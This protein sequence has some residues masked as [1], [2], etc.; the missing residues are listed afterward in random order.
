MKKAKSLLFISIAL[1]AMGCKNE[2]KENTTSEET[3][4][5]IDTV[6]IVKQKP[7]NE[8]NSTAAFDLKPSEIYSKDSLPKAKEAYAVI[9]E[10]TLNNNKCSVIAF[11]SGEASVTANGNDIQFRNNRESFKPIATSLVE[12]GQKSLALFT[13]LKTRVEPDQSHLK[14]YVLTGDGRYVFESKISEI[15]NKEMH[16]I[17]ENALKLFAESRKAM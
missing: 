7:I 17:Y 2:S 13:P 8:I 1:L 14:I 3:S 11:K 10:W 9:M 12:K 6:V 15:K 16:A 5:P 4:I